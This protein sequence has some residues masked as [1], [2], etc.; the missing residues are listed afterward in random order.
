M[1]LAITSASESL[2]LSGQCGEGTLTATGRFTTNGAGG[3]VFYHWVRNGVAQPQQSKVVNPGDKGMQVF[4]DTWKP[5]GA[6][7]EQLVFMSPSYATQTQS[8]NC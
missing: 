4:T 1:P 8:F 3:T 6:G 2:A 5:S 7:S